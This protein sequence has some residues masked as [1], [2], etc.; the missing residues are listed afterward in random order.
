VTALARLRPLLAGTALAALAATAAA[1][2]AILAAETRVR[3]SRRVTVSLEVAFTQRGKVMVE[4]RVNGHPVRAVKRV[5]RKGSRK[6]RFRFAAR[7]KHLRDLDGPITFDLMATA[8]ERDGAESAPRP[9]H[10]DVPVPVIVLGG[11]GNEDSLASAE[12]IANAID[13]GGIYD[14]EGKRPRLAVHRYASLSQP[15]TELGRELTPI[16]RRLRRR[17]PFKQVDVVGYSMG[18]LVARAWIALGG[19]EGKARKVVML[20]TPNEGTPIAYLG[21]GLTQAGLLD[22]FL[23][24]AGGLVDPF[25]EQLLD[26]ET[27]DALRTFYPTYPWLLGPLGIDL[28]GAV[29]PFLGD[30]T[31]PLETLNAIPPDPDAEYDALGYTA[32]G[33]ELLGV[34]LGT[35]DEIDALQLL[36]ILQ[37]GEGQAL[38]DVT[39]FFDGEGDGVVPARSVFLEDEPAWRDHPRFHAEDVGTGTHVTLPLDPAVAD[40]VRAILLGTG[41]P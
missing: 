37:A 12:S 7:R 20:G 32:A 14:R 36:S 11:L 1:D 13:A 4:G 22:A 5:K 40:R 10:V 31:S 25:V 23:G 19:G 33:S 18:G 38:P 26:E 28:S 35:L 41:A 24:D 9:V 8:T 16:A 39:G 27:T 6:V 17:S 34:E 2:P 3:R 21:V 30:A 29:E 15:L